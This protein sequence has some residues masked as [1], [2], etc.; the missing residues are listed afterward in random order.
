MAQFDAGRV[1]QARLADNGGATAAHAEPITTEARYDAVP[2]E[3][4]ALNIWLPFRTSPRSNGKLNK[5]PYDRNGGKASYTDPA[6]WMSYEECLD[7]LHAAKYDGLG[8]V[9]MKQLGIVG[10]DFDDCDSGNDFK[11]RERIAVL[12]TYTE[13]SF[14]GA[15][16]HCLA[17]GHLPP[18]GRK[19]P[20]I[21]MYDDSRYFVVT[22][23][24]LAGTPL[25]LASRELEIL[26]IHKEAW[27]DMHAA[28]TP[29]GGSITNTYL[30]EKEGKG[31]G[32]LVFDGSREIGDSQ[33]LSL[34]QQDEVASKYF[35][36]W[37][38]TL[39]DH[40]RADWALAGK[41]AFYCGNRL[42]QMERVFRRSGLYRPKC[43]ERR[44]NSTYLRDTL[45]RMVR[46]RVASGN[47][48]WKP[49]A[50]RKGPKQ[51]SVKDR[52]SETTK[53]VLNLR[54]TR[55]ELSAGAIGRELGLKPKRVRTIL[56][57]EKVRRSV[58]QQR[59]DMRE[60]ISGAAA[61]VSCPRSV[62]HRYPKPAPIRTEAA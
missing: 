15:G 6:E 50:P 56:H 13:V 35:Q 4:K 17:Y 44:R 1:D 34:L 23:N 29:K 58:L 12:N 20:D 2:T 26:T 14:S 5:A 40:S 54:A 48:C 59:Q 27:P 30:T 7:R 8:I 28:N 9:I 39:G 32:E 61:L 19:R 55:S 36:G 31:I 10:V 60:Q 51:T 18:Q 62:R 42:D 24:H 25:S 47:P 57:R 41:L 11:V 16:V 43:N 33:V 22:G 45:E 21:E 3:L 38:G 37:L 53:Q 46:V 49:G 52:R